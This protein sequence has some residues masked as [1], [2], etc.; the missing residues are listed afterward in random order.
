MRADPLCGD[1]RL[2]KLLPL[3]ERLQAELGEPLAFECPRL[4]VDTDDGYAPAVG[5]VIDRIDEIYSRPGVHDL[6]RPSPIG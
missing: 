4:V 6:D 3:A 2:R 5:V 1:E